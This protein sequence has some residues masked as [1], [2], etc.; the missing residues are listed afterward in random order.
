M[1]SINKQTIENGMN[2]KRDG[3]VNLA[4]AMSRVFAY[5]SA[6]MLCILQRMVSNWRFFILLLIYKY[7]MMQKAI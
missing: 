3:K 7:K 2:K 5:I 4:D 1:S 6:T